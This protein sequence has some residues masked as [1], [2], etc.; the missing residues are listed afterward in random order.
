MKR[1]FFLR[2]RDRVR[3]KP[4]SMLRQRSLTLFALHRIGNGRGF[5]AWLLACFG[6]RCGAFRHAHT[7]FSQ[8]PDLIQLA[9]VFGHADFSSG[10]A[11]VWPSLPERDTHACFG[12]KSG[13]SQ[14]F[15]T[16][17]RKAKQSTLRLM[18]RQVQHHRGAVVIVR[19]LG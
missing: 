15:N 12:Q 9:C 13:S 16:Q 7:R 19:R 14:I 6:R 11:K 4:A 18:W 8:R 2:L 17:S 10:L 3:D 5:C 1:P